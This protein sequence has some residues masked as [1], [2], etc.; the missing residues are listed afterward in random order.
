MDLQ[1]ILQWIMH[2]CAKAQTKARPAF[3][4]LRRGPRHSGA[5][6]EKILELLDARASAGLQSQLLQIQALHVAGPADDTTQTESI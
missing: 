5:L 1:G 6:L 4:K 3:C 2:L